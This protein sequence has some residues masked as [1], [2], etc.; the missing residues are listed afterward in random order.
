[1]GHRTEHRLAKSGRAS[2]YAC[3]LRIDECI[4]ADEEKYG[5]NAGEDF[6]NRVQQRRGLH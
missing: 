6:V 5:D 1:M 3:V 2:C 4:C